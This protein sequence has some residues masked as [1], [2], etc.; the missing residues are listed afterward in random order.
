MGKI[1][2]N[3]IEFCGTSDT[4]DNIIYDNKESGLT[5]TTT[6]NA[7]DELSENIDGLN[8]SVDGLNE[9]VSTLSDSLGGELVE[10]TPLNGATIMYN[11]STR[12]GN[13]IY[14]QLEIET[15]SAM[16][17]GHKPYAKITIPTGGFMQQYTPLCS[18]FQ[19]ATGAPQKGN[20]LVWVTNADEGGY[21]ITVRFV[22]SSDC[23]QCHIMGTVFLL[24]NY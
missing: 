24:G 21:A 13:V 3:G 17:D 19:N 8:E 5:A 2:R 18:A 11:Y 7:I 12:I 22:P 1:V 15:T 16:T 9:S 4:A 10:I 23:Y 6:Q 20:G 14:F